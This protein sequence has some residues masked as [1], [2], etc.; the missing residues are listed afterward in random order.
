[1]GTIS[2]KFHQNPLKTVGGVAET[3]LCLRTHEPKTIVHFDLRRG[4]K[5]KRKLYS[6]KKPGAKSSQAKTGDT[7]LVKQPKQNKL[8]PPFN[9][10]P[11]TVI[12]KKGSMA[13]VRHGDR[14]VTRD[15]SHFKEIPSRLA[16]QNRNNNAET[17]HHAKNQWRDLSRRQKKRPAC[18]RIMC[19]KVLKCVNRATIMPQYMFK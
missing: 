15:V 13:T 8:T 11:G 3:R 12:E 16:V 2:G 9:P 4:T 1:M 6:D 14:T 5:M 7:V 18:L 10:K 17:T 19:K